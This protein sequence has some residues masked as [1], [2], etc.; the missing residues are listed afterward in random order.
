MPIPR[1]EPDQTV[2][3]VVDIQERLMPSIVDRHRVIANSAILI[4]MAH[5]MEIPYLVTEHYPRGLGR[6]V[7]E[8]TAAM[9]DQSRRV[10][11]TRFSAWVDMVQQQ[12]EAWQ[13]PSVIICGVEAHVCV[14]QSVLDL[15]AAGYQSFVCSDAISCGQRDQ[16]PH[17]IRRMERA[18]AVTT[19]VLSVMYELME[20]AKHPAFKALLEL[21]KAVEQ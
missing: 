6:T 4:R 16:I 17:A 20:D 10:E 19:G 13:R 8:V 18:G 14:L 7:E 21:A 12:F 15:H 9:A 1:L 2:L 5:E 11:K 3:L